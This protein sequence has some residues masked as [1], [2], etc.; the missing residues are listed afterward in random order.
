LEVVI[1]PNTT[2]TVSV[3]TRKAASVMESGAPVSQVAGISLLREEGGAAV[4][5]VGSGRYHFE[6][7]E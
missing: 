2:A 6:V 1:P 4:Y 5:A 7:A 3:P